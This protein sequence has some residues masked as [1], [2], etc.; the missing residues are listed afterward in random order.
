VSP[1]A[2]ISRCSRLTAA[3]FLDYYFDLLTYVGSRQNR[4]K[5]FQDDVPPP[6]ETDEETYNQLWQKYT[7][8]ERANLRKRR[9]RLRHGDFQILTQ[10]GQGGYGQ[11]FLAQKKDTREVCALKVMSK[12][13]LF[14]LDEI[15]HVL[16]ERDILT[17]AK[18]EWLVRLLYSFQ[19]DKSIYL[20]M[21]YVPGGDF[22]T[23]LNNTGVLSNRHARFYIAEMFC[24]VDALH[25]LGYI[26][27]DLK[28]E[29]FL[30][31]STGHV[32]LTDFGLAA[33]M[34]APA[35]IESM[36]VRLEKASETSVPF[37]KP[38]D[39]RT[40]AERR[41]GYRS[42]RD[43]DLNYAK[44]I[45]GSP[46]YMAPEVLRGEEY[47]FT[48]DYWSLGCM[49]FE[50]LTGFPPFAGSTPDET[51]RNLKHWREVLRRPVWEDPNYFLSNRTWNF[52]TT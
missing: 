41:E 38:M 39:Q 37:G 34:L 40:V 27:R 6:P 9:V 50:A 10:V 42:M 46:D 31:D 16:T 5:A 33:G 21:E 13:L 36:R 18:S 19:D 17:S 15:R 26:H 2:S 44:S 20:A 14:K 48:V 8:R 23:L 1:K 32:K 30:V 49:L 43:K 4:L 52:I 47:D 22:R 51:W 24:A 25:K 3:D 11:V 28:P 45:V 7:G 29:N 35:A 12:K